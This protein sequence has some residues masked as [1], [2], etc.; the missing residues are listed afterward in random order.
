MRGTGRILVFLIFVAVSATF[1]WSQ[2]PAALLEQARAQQSSGDTVKAKASLFQAVK[3]F[4][5]DLL[6]AR[7]QARLLDSTG[8]PGRR[9]AYQHLYG[10]LKEQGQADAAVARRLA[11]LDLEAGDREGAMSLNAITLPAYQPFHPEVSGTATMHLPGPA[12]SFRRMAALSSQTPD[13]QLLAALTRN[14]FTLGFHYSQRQSRS[15]PTEYLLLLQRYVEMAR[16]LEKMGD[17]GGMLEIA[18][19][20]SSEPLLKVLGYRL[21]KPGC[22]PQA[23]LETEDPNRAF[24]TIDSGFPLAELE[25]SFRAGKAF[26]FRV[27]GIDVPVLFGVDAWFAKTSDPLD[28]LLDGRE[29]ARLYYAM[30][31][32]ESRTADTLRRTI[33]IPRLMDVGAVIDFY[34][35]SLLLENGHAVMPGG[36]ERLEQWAKMVGADPAKPAEFILALIDKDSGWLAAYA[37]SLQ[38][39]DARQQAYYYA[40]GRLERFYTA[41]RGSGANANSGAARPVFRPS[42]ELLLLPSRMRLGPD[43]RPMIPG[44]TAT[45]KSLFQQALPKNAPKNSA[46]NVNDPDDVIAAL[47]AK[48][49][50]YEENGLL[51]VFVALNEVDRRRAHP[52][53]AATIQALAHDYGRFSHH[54][55]LFADW[56][57]IS[58][59]SILKF[60]RVNDAIVKVKAPLL[61]ADALGSFQ[62]TVGL[63]EILARQSQIPE[64]DL[65]S[66]FDALIT[67]FNTNFEKG[68]A[69]FDASRAAVETLLAAAGAGNVRLV[70]AARSNGAGGVQDT[71]L[72]LLAGENGKTEA[73]DKRAHDYVQ[74]QLRGALDSQKLV[75][76]DT[77]FALADLLKDSSK[78]NP[79]QVLRLA[80]QLR[81]FHLPAVYVSAAERNAAFPGYWTE[82]H[83]DEL[84][85]VNVGSMVDKKA[86]GLLAPFLRDTLVGL[87]YAYYAPPGAEVMFHNPLFVR[88]HDFMGR[89]GTGTGNEI[90]G[91]G[92]ISGTGWPLSGGGRLVGALSGLPYGLAEAE[93]DFLVPQNT[94]ALIWSDLAPQM[95][96]SAVIPRWWQATPKQQRWVAGNQRFGEDLVA[97]AAVSVE[98]R[99]RVMSLLRGALEPRRRE[100]FENALAEGRVDMALSLVMPAEL[101]RLSRAWVTNSAPAVDSPAYEELSK[102]ASSPE[103]SEANISAMFGVPRPKLARSWRP[104]LLGM[105][106]LPALQGYSSRLMAES[107]ESNNLHWARLADE[108]NL[109]PSSLQWLAPQL[110]QRL[111]ELIFAN[112]H[113]D[114]PAL[115]RALHETSDEYRR[116]PGQVAGTVAE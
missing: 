65:G 68:P 54:Y 80:G 45:W 34:G 100:S 94:Q 60:L 92:K 116:A 104:E 88:S 39:L 74:T 4:P 58:D 112:H 55:A 35:D 89:N 113:E 96:I 27:R 42:A 24:V 32:L 84:R 8:D 6:L 38:Q 5:K 115:L 85:D 1:A 101:Y 62:A 7:A 66:S 78:A 102:L 22:G 105:S 48:M 2:G 43:G 61:K 107:W 17:A 79:D 36:P 10:L 63:W 25:S 12:E 90:W 111:I 11:L 26:K 91:P 50:Q 19:C 44:G 110:T 99:T 81:E 98:T 33:G 95:L 53:E 3:Q 76:L 57:E 70:T 106:L 51:N 41:I 69:L 73:A 40:N 97:E 28:Q 13:G 93:Q 64:K 103:V 72:N 67:P 9:E 71:L 108:M 21:R 52:L 23:V 15:A 49:R 29:T 75:R 114:W 56:P 87:N 16:E 47:Y 31:K 46:P 20:G 83:L 37:D 77:L 82:K 86:R 30:T 14:L 59:A 18:D 109:P